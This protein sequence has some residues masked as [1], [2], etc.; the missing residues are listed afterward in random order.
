MYEAPLPLPRRIVTAINKLGNQLSRVMDLSPKMLPF[1]KLASDSGGDPWI[2][3]R[4]PVDLTDQRDPLQE[5]M[6]KPWPA[7][8]KLSRA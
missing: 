3:G 2:V 8:G 4:I 5:Y 1:Q 6:S 7:H